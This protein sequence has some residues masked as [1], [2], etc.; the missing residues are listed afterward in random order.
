MDAVSSTRRLNLSERAKGRFVGCSWKR[1]LCHKLKFSSSGCM[2]TSVVS[3][4]PL[5]FFAFRFCEHKVL[6]TFNH[7]IFQTLTS[8]QQSTNYFQLIFPN[9]ILI[10]RHKC[11]WKILHVTV[12]SLD[13]PPVLP[14]TVSSP[15]HRLQPSLCVIHRVF[16]PNHVRAVDLE[17]LPGLW[18]Q[19][20]CLT[21]GTTRWEEYR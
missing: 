16:R 2:S 7:C 12:L 4:T 8:Q 9:L 20:W 17:Q 5:L 3:L 14:G 18:A 1:Q 19:T 13:L 10:R 15:V 6:L 21:A 11:I